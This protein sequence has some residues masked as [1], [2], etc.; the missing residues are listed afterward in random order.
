MAINVWTP[1]T[2]DQSILAGGQALGKG[3]AGGLG[4]AGE[5]LAKILQTYR[6]NKQERESTT[7]ALDVINSYVRSDPELLKTYGEELAKAPGMSNSAR[8]GL[9]GGLTSAMALKSQRQQQEKDL[10]L[11]QSYR[12]NA[13]NAR[14]QPEFMNRLSE[15]MSGQSIPGVTGGAIGAPEA[16]VENP[17]S[18]V[19]RAAGST[20][21]QV[22][23]GQLDDIIRAVASAREQQMPG[24]IQFDQDPKTGARFA[25]FGRSVLPSG[26]DPSRTMTA[27]EVL[28]QDN[29]PTGQLAISTG[30]GVQIVKAPKNATGKLI[31]AED[32]E[33]NII[34]GVYVDEAGKVHDLRSQMMKIG[35][36]GAGA[37]AAAPKG[38]ASDPLGLFDK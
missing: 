4:A 15:N 36:G 11:I 22:A 25:R 1:F 38:K 12:A 29:K 3:I 16:S 27:V 10:E 37:P 35:V 6:E 31:P 9:I 32:G 21:Y 24:P 30:R 2:A 5:G 26:V 18:A 14:R 19:A 20:G 28:D 34:P 13:E 23:P 7:A 8:K 17:I 33:G